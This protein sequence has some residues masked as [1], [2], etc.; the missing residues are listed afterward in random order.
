[1]GSG[2]DLFR[3]AVVLLADDSQAA[4]HWA[5]RLLA[6][7]HIRCDLRVVHDGEQALDYVLGQGRYQDPEVSPAPDLILL[8]ID[9]P[10]IDGITVLERLRDAGALDRCAVV[11]LTTSNDPVESSRC[12]AAGSIG[13][14]SKP[15]TAEKLFEVLALCA[16]RVGLALT[17][18]ETP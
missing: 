9:M 4:Q 6:S 8:D 2:T 15:L 17:A 5:R 3:Q 11:M 13:F 18:P 12:L 7:N 16:G 10:K 14:V 1:M